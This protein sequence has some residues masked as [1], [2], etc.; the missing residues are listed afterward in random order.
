MLCVYIYIYT[1]TYTYV[2]IGFV[3]TYFTKAVRRPGPREGGR[4]GPA[5]GRASLR[6]VRLLRVSTF[7]GLTQANS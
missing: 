7:E 5:E 4:S 3:H 2:H 6:P 1:H